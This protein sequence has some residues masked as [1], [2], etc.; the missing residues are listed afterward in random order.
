[1]GRFLGVCGVILVCVI[2]LGFY[3]EWFKVS[4]TSGEQKSNVE[5]TIDKQKLKEDEEKAKQKSNEIKEEIKEKV[6][7]KTEK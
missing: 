6:R 5:I 3:M 1:M 2:C 4:T 7:Q